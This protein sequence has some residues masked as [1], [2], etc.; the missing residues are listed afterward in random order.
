[1]TQIDRP[2]F[3]RSDAHDDAVLT[4]PIL[5]FLVLG[6]GVFGGPV[7]LPGTA[8]HQVTYEVSTAKGTRI[9]ATYTRSQGA[10]LTSAGVSCARSP[11][12][13]TAQVSGVV[14]PTLTAS[15]EADT[16]RVNRSDTIVCT[17]IE[18]G[19]QVAQDSRQPAR[20]PW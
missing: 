10:E 4:G 7:A 17:I 1:M 18:D 20:T 9:T 12:S 6:T 2:P 19:V 11:W 16:G 15:L 3:Y 8:V 5:L 13:A 14:G